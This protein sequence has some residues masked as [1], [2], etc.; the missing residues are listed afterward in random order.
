MNITIETT[1]VSFKSKQMG[2]NQS[3]VSVVNDDP[4]IKIILLGDSAVGKSK[5]MERFL[6]DQYQPR[7]VSKGT[8]FS[9]LE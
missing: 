9:L 3:A 6:E 1:E 7:R 5:L 8:E 2:D 4:D